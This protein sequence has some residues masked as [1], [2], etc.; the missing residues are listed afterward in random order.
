MTSP[1]QD[2]RILIVED[3]YAIAE[4]LVAALEALGSAVVG[5]APSVDKALATIDREPLIDVAIVDI[6]LRGVMA[7]AVADRLMAGN[8]PFVFTSGYGADI[9]RNRYPGIKNCQKPYT[10]EDI[11][12]AL[13]SAM[14]EA[15]RRTRPA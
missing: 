14:S 11:E 12:Q 4:S 3:E 5:P 13:A 6:N 10:I 2:R 9:L 8:I 7:E 15:S 1:L